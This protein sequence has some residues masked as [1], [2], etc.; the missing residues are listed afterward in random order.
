[1]MTLNNLYG[2][3]SK[4]R[5]NTRKSHTTRKN[6][7]HNKVRKMRGGNCSTCQ[8]SLSGGGIVSKLIVPGS[9]FAVQKLLQ[10]RGSRKFLKR[11]DKK[12]G[13][14]GKTLMKDITKGV[15]KGVSVTEKTLHLRKSKKSKKS[16]R[17]R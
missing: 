16:N 14:T 8:G 10:K 15:K 2:G 12:L 17:R 1:M 11:V 3:K 6:R 4:R 7:K 9:L 5:V 13:R